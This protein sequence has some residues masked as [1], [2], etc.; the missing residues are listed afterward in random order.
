MGNWIS[1]VAPF[2]AESPLDQFMSFCGHAVRLEHQF[3]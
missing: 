2:K 3:G 1:E